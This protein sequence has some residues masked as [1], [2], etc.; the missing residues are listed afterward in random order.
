LKGRYVPQASSSGSYFVTGG[1][2][3]VGRH[4]L[5]A[6]GRCGTVTVKVLTRGS[7]PDQ[8]SPDVHYVTG[9]LL[10]PDSFEGC[11]QSDDIVINLAYLKEGSRAD[12]LQATAN[13]ASAALRRTR[14]KRIV[15]CSTAV[16]VGD[17]TDRVIDE[18]TPCRPRSEYEA[19]KYAVEEVFWRPEFQDLD[20]RILRP[21]VI[22]GAG[23]VNL[24]KTVSDL[25]DGST[26]Q[27]YLRLALYRDRRMNLVSV[28]NVA[29]A[30]GFLSEVELEGSR[31][32]FY[33]SDDDDR[34]NTYDYVAHRIGA[35]FAIP[36]ILWPLIPMPGVVL[37]LVLRLAGRS[38]RN[39]MRI[40]S[41]ASLRKAGFVP[42][43][44]LSEA[45]EQFLD[46]MATGRPGTAAGPGPG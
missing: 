25:L 18:H 7:V 16:V 20:V 2:G 23:G 3:F 41:S 43:A 8:P 39:P 29:A 38:S 37:S 15:H 34:A 32:I 19:T 30:L 13:V 14:L 31:K 24:Q 9:N 46:S 10:D 5:S 1:T 33:L 22:F 12:N 4:L 6:M 27:N 26:L 40:Y 42:P 44:C 21:A 35:H 11:I 17:S 36:A 28:E 45:L